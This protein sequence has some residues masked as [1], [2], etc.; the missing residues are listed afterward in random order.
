MPVWGQDLAKEAAERIDNSVV[1]FSCHECNM[2]PFE[3]KM[4]IGKERMRK[5]RRKY[6]PDRVDLEGSRHRRR[7]ITEGRRK[8]S[9]Y[10]TEER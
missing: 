2:K 6:H 1:S 9:L 3:A 8:F 5:H 7:K 10:K 4:R